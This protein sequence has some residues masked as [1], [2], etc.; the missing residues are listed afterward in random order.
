MFRKLKQQFILTNLAIIMV[1]FITL[2]AG[3][4]I[5]L[6]I[7]MIN[8]AQVFSKRMAEGINSGIFPEFPGD[9]HDGTP[10]FNGRPPGGNRKLPEP[11][12]FRPP[13][14]PRNGNQMMPPFFYIKMNSQRGIIFQSPGLPFAGTQLAVLADRFFKTGQNSGIINFRHSKFFYYKTALAKLPGTLV[15]F[16]DL[17]QEKKI[18]QLMV[19]SL[20]VIGIIF[21]MLSMAGSLFMAKRAIQPIQKIWQ[22]QKDF[23]A[24]VSHELRTPLTVI[25]T[26]LEVVLSN[27]GETVAS[28]MDWLTNV[29]EELQQMTGL[30]TS[31]LF[32]TRLDSESYRI[33]KTNFSLDKVAVGVTEAFKPLV[34]AKNIDLS[35]TIAGKISA[36]GDESNIRRVME[37]L[38]DNA[39]QYTP[40]GGRISL[41]LQQPDKKI[42]LEVTDTGEGI[43]TE[44]LA[45]IFDR[46]YQVDSS[47]SKGKAGLGLSIAKSIVENHGGTIHVTSQPGLGTTFTI[48]LPLP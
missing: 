39:I 31:L 33:E 19:V 38:L 45:K 43:G 16:Q 41:Q 13:A 25:R 6:Q 9:A 17:K 37:I 7:N 21:L 18:Q 20:M 3:V 30:V 12:T 4:Y 15:V 46:F 28:Q 42:L 40:A 22:Q 2:T 48:Q 11:G 8:H 27:P 47:R 5:V 36:Y 34:A 35:T 24:D 10:H 1:L 14:P 26:N 29:R 23:L 44:H 32:L